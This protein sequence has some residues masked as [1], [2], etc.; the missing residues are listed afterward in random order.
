MDVI[1][2]NPLDKTKNFKFVKAYITPQGT[3]SMYYP[4][5]NYRIYTQ[6]ND[7]TRCF[8]SVDENNILE[9]DQMLVP[10]FGEKAEDRVYEKWRGTKNKKKRVYAF[11]D[12]AQAVKCWCIKADFA[13]TSSSHNT[14]IARLWGDTLRNST[15]TIDNNEVN[16][17]KTTAQSTIERI[18]NNNVNGDMPDIRTTIDGFPIVVFG[19]KSYGEELVFLGKYNFNNDKSTESVFGF[20]DIDDETPIIDNSMVT[21][22]QTSQQWMSLMKNGKM[23]LSLDTLKLLRHLM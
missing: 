7:D 20:C 9:L 10:N 6:K 1:Y 2:Y 15:V 14:G 5:K 17:F 21:H 8:F 18:Y 22:W 16:V 23:H 12:N 11:K 3:S 4:K 13:E 19:A